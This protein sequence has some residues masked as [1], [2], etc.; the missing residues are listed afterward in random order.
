MFSPVNPNLQNPNVFDSFSSFNTLPATQKSENTHKFKFLQNRPSD[1]FAARNPKKTDPNEKK[2]AILYFAAIISLGL[3]AAVIYSKLKKYLIPSELRTLFNELKN[4]EGKSFLD[5]AYKG[6]V[7]YMGLENIAPE[8][9]NIATLEHG[10]A[11]YNFIDH[12]VTC[13][14]KVFDM[15]KDIQFST[16]GHELKH[17]KQFTTML[18]SKE[19]GVEHYAHILTLRELNS[20][21]YIFKMAISSRWGGK[22]KDELYQELYS[23]YV[24]TVKT[25]FA[26]VL[27][28][29]QINTD[30]RNMQSL[31]KKYIIGF[32]TY[33]LQSKNYDNNILEK[34]AYKWQVKL[35]N[36]FN[37]YVKS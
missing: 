34:E 12:T 26:S 16:L 32:A 27:E 23:K 6:L 20:P 18:R 25:N 8:S 24:D 29:P 28:Q 35:I 22:T 3:T 15:P 19:V 30:S 14:P 7:K 31:I 10:E 1:I 9:I 5:K 11:A 21:K 2:K 36:M 13:D 4:E 37:T 33:D 17:C